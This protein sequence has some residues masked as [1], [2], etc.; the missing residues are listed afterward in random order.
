M[1]NQYAIQL[2]QNFLQDAGA[3]L[4]PVTK[5]AFQRTINLAHFANRLAT[6]LREITK[7]EVS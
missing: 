1:N 3:H 4:D 7:Q 5:E 6:D 2:V